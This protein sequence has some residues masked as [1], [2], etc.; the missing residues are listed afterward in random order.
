SQMKGIDAMLIL[1]NIEDVAEMVST[2][3][4]I[5]QIEDGNF[6][7]W[8]EVVLGGSV[9]K[10]QET[11]GK[12]PQINEYELDVSHDS[13]EKQSQKEEAE[14]TNGVDGEA[15]EQCQQNQQT[16]T[17]LP[18]A[19]IKSQDIQS[20]RIGIH[21]LDELMNMV[22]ELVVRKLK[23]ENSLP[24]EIKKSI[25]GEFS[26]FER[27]LSRL[28]DT[29]MDLRLIPLKYVVDRLPRL[30]RD[31][32]KSLGKEIDF[33]IEGK[34]VT[35]DRTVLDKIQDPLIHIIRNSVDHGIETPEIREKAG[36]N[37]VGKLTLS[38][39]KLKDH[40]LIE[41]TDDGQGLDAEKIKEKAIEKGLTSKEEVAEMSPDEIY[42]L[43]L[44]PGFSTAE[45]ITDVS[46]RGVGTD[47]IQNTVKSLGGSVEVSSQKGKG[48]TFKL[49]L[50]LSMAISQILLVK[51][52]D[53]KYGIPIKDILKVEPIDKCEIGYAGGADQLVMEDDII[54][55]IH[56][57]RAL[58]VDHEFN[59]EKMIII[60][61]SV[62]RKVA[63]ACDMVLDQK[64]VV[65]KSL[66]MLKSVEGI[67]GISILGEGEVVP[68][69]DVN[70]L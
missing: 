52:N 25:G 57:K 23:L 49:R 32:S 5:N 18:R 35:V 14:E 53:E 55:I 24:S 15:E 1:K 36:K 37:R 50:P 16:A 30:V 7:D 34:E 3:P 43:I 70:T 10:V 9:E 22:E 4:S 58:G 63:L 67:S 56:L 33:Q 12:L 6:E 46:G 44:K 62:D 47:I 8:F 21:K 65:V 69:L 26:T 28:Q 64:E 38:A 20:I 59:S 39:F 17:G 60:A 40:V 11:L 66:G 42:T 51:V 61:S 68:I 27:I 41:I 48:T 31:L 29:V 13:Q 2:T 19:K 45:Q 54:P